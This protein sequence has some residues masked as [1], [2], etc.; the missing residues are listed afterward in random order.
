MARVGRLAQ[1]GSI[2]PAEP[3]LMHA[4]ETLSVP[5]TPPGVRQAIDAF[6]RFGR[7]YQLP[8]ALEWRVLLALDEMLS[9]ID[10]HGAPDAAAPVD[11]A[12]TLDDGVVTVEIGDSGPPFNPLQ[13]P[14]PDTTSPLH[15]RQPG[16]LGISLVRSLMDETMY[17][18][19]DNRNYFV[20]RCGTHADR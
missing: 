2:P 6:E 7:T 9:N 14:P 4:V 19:R 18:R 3:D 16:G 11:L 15:S 13:A 10:R 8:R 17:E 20:M 12:F 1:G 5:A